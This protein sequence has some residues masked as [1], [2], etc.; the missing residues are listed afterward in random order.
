MKKLC[1]F[2]IVR[3]GETEW[4][5]KGIMQGQKNSKAKQKWYFFKQKN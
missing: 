5:V 1:T 4:N 3:H 2:Y